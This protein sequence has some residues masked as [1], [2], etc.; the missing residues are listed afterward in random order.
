M[1][2]KIFGI[3]LVLIIL[4]IL[5]I[6]PLGLGEIGII[7]SQKEIKKMIQEINLPKEMIAKPE[8]SVS[9]T[10]VLN[11]KKGMLLSPVSTATAV[12]VPAVSEEVTE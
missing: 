2:N 10:P 7:N 6:F 4:V 12:P 8:G 5:I 1:I 9:V 3:P 11:S